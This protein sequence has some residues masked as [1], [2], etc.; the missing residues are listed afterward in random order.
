MRKTILTEDTKWYYSTDRAMHEGPISWASLCALH[1]ARHLTDATLVWCDEIPE[2]VELW[3]VFAE[4]RPSVPPLPAAPTSGTRNV[5]PREAQANFIEMPRGE[6]PGFLE[7][8]GDRAAR[9]SVATSER[10]EDRRA[11]GNAAFDFLKGLRSERTDSGED[12]MYTWA[13]VV[14]VVVLVLL[15]VKA[16]IG[17]D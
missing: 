9:R 17:L 11:A 16:F 7:D 5:D 8:G 3:R 2:W 4:T 10:A 1:R 15:G 12:G 13:H 14:I 6:V